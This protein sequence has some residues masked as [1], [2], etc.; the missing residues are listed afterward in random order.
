MLN[1]LSQN[2]QYPHTIIMEWNISQEGKI[3]YFYLVL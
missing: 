1:L 2:Y 3:N